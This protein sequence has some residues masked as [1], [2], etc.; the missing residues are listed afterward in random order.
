[1]SSAPA[2]PGHRWHSW[3]AFAVSL[4]LSILHDSED[5][6]LV[7]S[8]R[9][10]RHP[11]GSE[12]KIR[13]LCRRAGRCTALWHPG[14]R[15]PVRNDRYGRLAAY[16]RNGLQHQPRAPLVRRTHAGDVIV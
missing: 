11:P 16:F 5:V 6:G 1:M 7:P 13:V 4:L 8:G 9:P 12:A 10:T 15:C 3:E 14:D 2:R